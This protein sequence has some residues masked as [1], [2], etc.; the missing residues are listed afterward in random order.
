MLDIRWIADRLGRGGSLNG[1][2]VPEERMLRDYAR[3]RGLT[4][5]QL[6]AAWRRDA[7]ALPHR[8]SALKAAPVEA[9]FVSED[10]DFWADDVE[11]DDDDE[12]DGPRVCGACHG[13]GF[14]ST[15]GVCRACGGTGKAPGDE[16]DDEDGEPIEDD[17]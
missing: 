16:E 5:E 7:S 3:A 12:L 9:H 2:N 10:L 1:L 13:T 11:P 6:I 15:G 17:D 14:D 8:R 4:A